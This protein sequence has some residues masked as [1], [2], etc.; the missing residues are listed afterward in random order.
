MHR[1][2]LFAA[3]LAAA[4]FV[5]VA[6]GAALAH[7]A[8]RSSDPSAGSVLTA[9]PTRIRLVFSEALETSLST[10]SLV[11][12]DGRQMALAARADSSDRK[13][14]IA[15]VNGLAAGTY[16]VRW[17]AV[18][19]DG[20]ASSGS[21]E[22]QVAAQADSSR[23][24]AALTHAPGRGAPTDTAAATTIAIAGA[25]VLAS[26]LR[27]VGITALMLTTGMLFFLAWGDAHEAARPRVAIG[28][29]GLVAAVLLSAHFFVWLD[30]IAPGHQ[31]DA[32]WIQRAMQTLPAR[33]E[34]AR[35]LLTILALVGFALARRIGTSL[36]LAT[37]ALIVS[38]AIGHP[39][40]IQPPLAIPAKVIHLLA[41]ALWGGGLAWLITRERTNVEMYGR[42]AR[43]VSSAALLAVILI[44]LSGVAQALLFMYSPSDLI[45][46]GYGIVLLLKVLGLLVLIGFGV[47]HRAR[48]AELRG[49]LAGHALSR[50]VR[51]E[52]AVFVI[53]GLL[54]A[55]LAY[56]PPRP[57]SAGTD[58][59][60]SG[61]FPHWLQR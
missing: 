39:A 9:P 53:V 7:A 32:A 5:L 29:L 20:H 11:L 26:V 6:H 52:I 30:H 28:W 44:V 16:H 46:T 12:P 40:A 15:P 61:P 22:F 47:Y 17:R 3:T 38:G 60:A 41:G 19:D 4:G 8:L 27:G 49:S 31:L 43:R 48:V 36:L 14:L 54:G 58:S 34:L 23:A 57:A 45:H 33:L 50:T 42:E 18:S 56:I 35:V 25:P 2:R 1:T 13:I 37:F 21:F 55:L 24:P 59:Y 51:Y 10:V